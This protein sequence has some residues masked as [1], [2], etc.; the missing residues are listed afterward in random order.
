M[1]DTLIF[2]LDDTLLVNP[3]ETFLPPYF[4]ALTAY[5]DGHVPIERLERELLRATQAM[6][7]DR[8]PHTTNAE[9]FA[10]V[11]YPA[12]GVDPA[13]VQPLIDRF[14]E[15]QFPRL[16]AVTRPMPGSRETVALAH[17]R[18]FGLVIA[19]NSVFP[20]RAIQHR[21]DWAEVGDFPYRLITAYEIMRWTKPHPEYYHEILDRIDRRP[22][23]C[24]MIGNDPRQDIVPARAVGMRTFFIPRQSDLGLPEIEATESDY[25]G[26]LADLRGLIETSAL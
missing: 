21:L 1:I 9:V 6:V 10:R 11:F 7:R 19:T 24:L 17:E 15:D 13:A 5:L 23:Q 26:T 18:G 4:A 25:R 8:D 2:D 3:M 22:E 20:L 14:Y 16:R 12:L